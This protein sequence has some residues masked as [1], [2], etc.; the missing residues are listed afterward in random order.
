MSDSQTFQKVANLSEIPE[1]E[2]RMFPFGEGSVAICKKD[3]EI[4]AVNN[5]CSHAH[6]ELVP[7]PLREFQIMCPLHGARFDVRTGKPTCLP[8]VMP[9]ATY[10][11]EKRAE[12]IWL[13][14][15]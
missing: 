11:V 1:G 12:E 15:K 4:Y 8:A 5:N 10:D 6:S 7:G 14:K 3:G 2:A 13:A 9:I